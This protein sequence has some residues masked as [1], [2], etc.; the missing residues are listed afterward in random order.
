MMIKIIIR[1]PSKV[2]AAWQ[3]GKYILGGFFI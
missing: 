1:K 3:A 2:Y